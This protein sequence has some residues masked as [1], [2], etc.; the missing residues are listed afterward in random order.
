MGTHTQPCSAAGRLWFLPPTE[1]I[2]P[3]RKQKSPKGLLM[4]NLP[5]GGLGTP[6]VPPPLPSSAVPPAGGGQECMVDTGSRSS[7][8]QMACGSICGQLW[9]RCP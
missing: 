7:C 4:S 3:G 6:P 8:L 1:E 2:H 5:A 9:Q